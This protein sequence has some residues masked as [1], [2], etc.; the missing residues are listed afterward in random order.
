MSEKNIF[1]TFGD[2]L[3]EMGRGI[4]STTEGIIDSHIAPVAWIGGFFDEDFKKK[5]AETIAYDWTSDHISQ[6]GWEKARE[7][8]YLS[9]WKHETSRLPPLRHSPGRFQRHYVKYH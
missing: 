4:I 9:G 1:S 5:A 6:W 7:K 3:A 8:S 2:L